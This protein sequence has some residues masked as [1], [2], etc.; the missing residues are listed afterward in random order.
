VG[1]EIR[2]VGLFSALLDE[3][4]F[5]VGEAVEL[6]DEATH[7]AV[8]GFDLTLEDGVLVSDAS[9]TRQ[10]LRVR[11]RRKNGRHVRRTICSPARAPAWSTFL[12]ASCKKLINFSCTM[13]HA[14]YMNFIR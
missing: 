2:F 3:G 5:F 10:A 6:V 4:D 13:E 11:L 1:A 7:L 8:G 14:Q 12:R 9:P